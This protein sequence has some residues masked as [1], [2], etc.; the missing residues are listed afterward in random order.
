MKYF[1]FSYI[2][3]DLSHEEMAAHE[4]WYCQ[5][6][7]L[8]SEQKKAIDRWRLMKSSKS[9]EETIE[10]PNKVCPI[11]TEDTAEKKRRIEDWRVGSQR[12]TFLS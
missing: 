8:R 11:T 4:E 9:C 1:T 3:S 6:E 10:A 12:G 7:H 5:Y 2:S